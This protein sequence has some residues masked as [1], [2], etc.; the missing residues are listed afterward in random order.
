MLSSLNP[1]IVVRC[2][3]GL[4]LASV[5]E[6]RERCHAR[7]SLRVI[8]L[9]YSHA[10]GAND[11]TFRSKMRTPRHLIILAGNAEHVPQ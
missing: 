7:H 10:A 5:G 3:R 2:G 9:W 8:G 11:R 1:W 6:L 4:H